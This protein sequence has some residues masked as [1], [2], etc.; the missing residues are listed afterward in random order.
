M[1]GGIAMVPPLF[2]YE[3][4]LIALVGLFLLSVSHLLHME[5]FTGLR[6]S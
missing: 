5:F 2:Y 4:G 1:S 3:L 6:G